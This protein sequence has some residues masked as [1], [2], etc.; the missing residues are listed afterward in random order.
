MDVP[1]MKGLYAML[2]YELCLFVCL[3]V[4]VL[5]IKPSAL[6]MLSTCSKL[7]YT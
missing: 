3:F 5:K 4:V 2:G 1:D 6:Y 7:A